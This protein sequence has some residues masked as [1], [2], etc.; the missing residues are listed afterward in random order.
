MKN[1]EKLNKSLN[2]E[3]TIEQQAVIMVITWSIDSLPKEYTD[4]DIDNAVKM[5][6]HFKAWLSEEVEE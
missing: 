6:E 2:Q 5:Y 3:K 1:Y 4:E